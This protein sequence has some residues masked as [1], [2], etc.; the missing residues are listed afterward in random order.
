MD[1]ILAALA[2]SLIALHWGIYTRLSDGK[3][4]TKNL[5][6]HAIGSPQARYL[7]KL[8]RNLIGAS[9]LFLTVIAV[10]LVFIPIMYKVRG[11]LFAL[12]VIWTMVIAM[13]VTFVEMF[14]INRA[15]WFRMEMLVKRAMVL[16]VI[17]TVATLGIFYN[18]FF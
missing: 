16:N 10:I 1:F 8:F 9:I 3:L 6:V 13:F 17:S 2:G 18:A 15:G 7:D 12:P 14:A 5:Q 4:L 11:G